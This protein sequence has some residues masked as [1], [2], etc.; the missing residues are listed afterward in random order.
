M[1][2][3][4]MEEVEMYKYQ[5]LGMLAEEGEDATN[6]AGEVRESISNHVDDI[7][8]KLEGDNQKGAALC[9]ILLAI[10]DLQSK[11]ENLK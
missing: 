6:L 3:N 11:I 8:N 2:R 5:V 1:R 4:K 9:G 10:V 7:I